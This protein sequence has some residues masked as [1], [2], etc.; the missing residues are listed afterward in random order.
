MRD[1]SSLAPSVLSHRP[2]LL[3][4]RV[5]RVAGKR[6]NEGLFTS[7]LSLIAKNEVD[8]SHDAALFVFEVAI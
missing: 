6:M 3:A 7:R 8:D 5:T 2:S 4:L 1:S